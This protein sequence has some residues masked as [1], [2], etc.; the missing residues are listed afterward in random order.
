MDYTSSLIWLSS[1]PVLIYGTYQL[2]I[3]TV[4]KFDA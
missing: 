1:W 3:F 2:I 4:K